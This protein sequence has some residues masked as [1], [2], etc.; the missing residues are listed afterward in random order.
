MATGLPGVGGK[1]RSRMLLAERPNTLPPAVSERTPTPR[2]RL[3]VKPP[4][5]L[6]GCDV[7]VAVRGVKERVPV[8][9]RTGASEVVAMRGAAPCSAIVIELVADDASR[10]PSA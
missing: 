4:K 10:V 8:M 1:G 7:A 2:P 3:R 9:E 6:I 5:A